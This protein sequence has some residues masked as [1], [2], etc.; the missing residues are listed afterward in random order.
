ME[1]FGE[2]PILKKNESA[3]EAKIEQPIEPAFDPEDMANFNDWIRSTVEKSGI[4]WKEY[5]Q[6]Y[7]KEGFEDYLKSLGLDQQELKGKK[8][9]DL[10]A[11]DRSFAAYCLK[12][13]ISD[14]VF[15]VEPGGESYADHMA[16][17][18]I[19]T[20]Q[21]KKA[22]DEKT[23]KALQNSLPFEKE[24]FDVLLSNA[25]M[26]G[27]D[28]RFRAGLSMEEDLSR[29]Y[30]EIVRV[31]AKGG[32]A[33]LGPFFEEKD[34]DL[35]EPWQKAIRDWEIATKKKIVELSKRQGLQVE[36]QRI[37]NKMDGEYDFFRINIKKE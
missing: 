24:S 3:L 31:L 13:G 2:I 22:I 12:N 16:K 1:T 28:E 21:Q 35:K 5:A 9:L 30:E 17:K 37:E 7:E 8:I 11:G 15:S 19:W 34:N 33:R 4:T 25:A 6:R 29:S 36:V 10:G 20:E 26:P 18:E 14:Q 27:R 23:V 32:E